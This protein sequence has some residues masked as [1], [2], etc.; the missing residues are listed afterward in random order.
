MTSCAEPPSE[1]PHWVDRLF[2]FV[3]GLIL[4]PL[5]TAVLA[6]ALVAVGLSWWWL[7]LPGA[8]I[9]FGPI[10]GVLYPRFAIDVFDGTSVA[11]RPL[12]NWIVDLVT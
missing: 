5:V 9:V 12:S 1:R 6:I 8:G 2:G 11:G 7:V 10:V 3:A 4:G